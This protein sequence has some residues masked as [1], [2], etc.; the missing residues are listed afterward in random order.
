MTAS[1][2]AR[3][4]AASAIRSGD[5]AR[6]TREERAGSLPQ[7][8]DGTYSHRLDGH[9]PLRPGP[10]RSPAPANARS[11]ATARSAEGRSSGSGPFHTLRAFLLGRYGDGTAV[12]HWIYRDA[13]GDEVFRVLRVDYR[14]PTARPP[15]ATAPATGRPTDKWLLSRPDGPLP[16]YNLPAILAAPP[17]GGHRPARRREM[18]RPRRRPGP[19]PRHDQCPRCESPAAHRLV[20]AGRPPRRHPPRRGRR[21]RG[22]RGQVA[23]LLAAL[24]PPARVQVVSLPGLADGEDIE[25]FIA[26][27]RS[28]GRTDADILAELQA[29]IASGPTDRP[30]PTPRVDPNQDVTFIGGVFSIRLRSLIPITDTTGKRTLGREVQD[31][32]T[33][34]WS[35]LSIPTSGLLLNPDTM[36]GDDSE[37]VQGRDSSPS[38]PASVVYANYDYRL[39]C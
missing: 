22:L 8:R 1:S 18:R 16:L 28:A 12:R 14:L 4:S 35:I 17:R 39:I 26:A 24:D 38:T 13:A 32:D 11:A 2:A 23:A 33:P 36:Q 15:R 37:Q 7:N 30:G 10:R 20:A 25:Q 5:Y 29:L 6:C 27:R 34:N 9:M 19:A 3:A 31:H 21:R